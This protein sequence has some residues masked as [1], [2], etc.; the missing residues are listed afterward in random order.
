MYS[1][2]H[3]PHFPFCLLLTTQTSVSSATF[4]YSLILSL[5]FIRTCTFVWII[6]TLAFHCTTHTT[7][8]S[9][10]SAGFEPANP[11]SHRPQ[12]LAL[13]GSVTGFGIRAPDSSARIQRAVPTELSR[14]TFTSVNFDLLICISLVKNSVITRNCNLYILYIYTHTHNQTRTLLE[15]CEHEYSIM[16]CFDFRGS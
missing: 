9:K 15:I 10:P 14:P 16:Q 12:T 11:A 2:L 7:Q 8:I 4:F 5:Y 1:L 13:D 3:C 6:L